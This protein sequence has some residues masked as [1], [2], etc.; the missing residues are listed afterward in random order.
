MVHEQVKM[1]ETEIAKLKMQ[2]DVGCILFMIWI[3]SVAIA[4]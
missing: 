2:A 4:M 1:Q 3:S